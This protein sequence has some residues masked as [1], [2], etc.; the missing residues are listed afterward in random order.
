MWNKLQVL[1]SLGLAA[2]TGANQGETGFDQYLVIYNKKAYRFHD[3]EQTQEFIV[4]PEYYESVPIPAHV[5]V[6]P[7]K[8]DL[9]ALHSKWN[10][11]I[12]FLPKELRAHSFSFSSSEKVHGIPGWLSC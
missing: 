1:F 2:D 4:K 6:K 11:K 3:E 9:Q 8:M 12:R 5:N 7:P 10:K